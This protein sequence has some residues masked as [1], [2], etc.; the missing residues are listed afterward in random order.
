MFAQHLIAWAKFAKSFKQYR[1]AIEY[2]YDTDYF[3]ADAVNAAVLHPK[4]LSIGG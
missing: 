3:L 2:P 1:R 4:F